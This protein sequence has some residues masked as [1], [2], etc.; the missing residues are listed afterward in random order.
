MKYGKV[1]HG[2]LVRRVNRFIAEV[3]IDGLKEQVH[4]KNTGRLK[5][6]LQPEAEV[7]LERS[8]NPNRRTR[9]SLIAAAKHGAWVNIDS[10]APNTVAFEAFKE[11]RIKEFGGLPSIRREVAYKNSRFD[12]YVE[13]DGRKGFVE[14]KGVTLESNGIALFPDAPTSRGTKHVLE[15][16]QAIHEGYSGTIL[17]V[18]QMKGCHAFMPNRE[19]DPAFAN[20]LLEAS[21]HGVQILAYDSIVKE[22]ELI[23]DQVLPVYLY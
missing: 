19:M 20:A 10:Q 21:R 18:V 3:I 22:D 4:I 23:L 11:G 1:V 9:Y 17:F 15:L 5:E 13:Q 12:L 8:D 14:V 7:L 2:R 16:I 6:L